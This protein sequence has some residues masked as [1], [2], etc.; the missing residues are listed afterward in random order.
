MIRQD[1]V[2]FVPERL[3]VIEKMEMTEFMYDNVVNDA[4]RGHHA[5]S[6]EGKV[7]SW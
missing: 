7:A 1:L 2:H 3:S 6:M 4:G 5:L